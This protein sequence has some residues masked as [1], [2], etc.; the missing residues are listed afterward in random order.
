M[1]LTILLL[2][3]GYPPVYAQETSLRSCD[4]QASDPDGD[5][6][7]WEWNRDLGAM[8]S[9]SV[10]E[11]SQTAPARVNPQTGEEV[12]LIRAYW[13]AN[14]DIAGRNIECKAYGWN[15]AAG[16]FISESFYDSNLLHDPLPN[17]LPFIAFADYDQIPFPRFPDIPLYKIWT[18]IDG[19]YIGPMSDQVFNSAADTDY[20]ELI[21]ATDSRPAGI[22][23]WGSVMRECFDASGAA[24]TPTGFIGEELP[25]AQPPVERSLIVTGLPAPDPSQPLT[26]LASGTAVTL[27]D[28]Y[29]DFYK[30]FWQ[31]T[32]T[33][34]P[35]SWNGSSY[36]PVVYNVVIN[37]FYAA[38]KGPQSGF[39]GTRFGAF[40]VDGGTNETWTV[41]D[42]RLE[43]SGFWPILIHD[44]VEIIPATAERNGVVR[45]WH[46]SEEY[47]ECWDSA[48]L[49]GVYENEL[50]TKSLTPLDPD[51]IILID[52]T[53][54]SDTDAVDT[55]DNSSDND[56][57][58]DNIFDPP[59]E[60][61]DNNST[62]TSSGGGALS[63]WL[64]GL[65]F[66]YFRRFLLTTFVKL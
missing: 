14:R 31:R 32:I 63:Y 35:F 48:G 59:T 38:D 2:V 51:A 3:S 4:T 42:G 10:T 12:R 43:I 15:A 26:N 30:H 1:Q 22:R 58:S 33:C 9:C 29:W 18:V 28:A 19:R 62:V 53:S 37:R 27:S 20:I 8:A 61:D 44:K 17:E 13:N 46:S 40:G 11:N 60:A 7:G 57:V 36:S 5:G 49:I 24:F 55:A 16:A 50:D 52:E 41:I 6:F 25:A 34:L 47:T 23:I 21:D 65:L 56:N 66:V 64:L 45:S 39:V 54:P